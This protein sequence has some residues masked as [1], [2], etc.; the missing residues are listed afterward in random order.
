MV[1]DIIGVDGPEIVVSIGRIIN[2]VL[3]KFFDKIIF[4]GGGDFLDVINRAEAGVFFQ[5]FNVVDITVP[6]REG[7]VGVDFD[8]GLD[9]GEDIEVGIETGFDPVCDVVAVEIE[10]FFEMPLLGLGG[11]QPSGGGRAK[12]G[13]K[14]KRDKEEADTGVG[15]AGYFGWIWHAVRFYTKN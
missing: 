13:Q 2:I 15:A 4:V 3:D 10:G 1:F 9:A 14:E 12:G 6:V 7:K 11:D 5:D 8:K